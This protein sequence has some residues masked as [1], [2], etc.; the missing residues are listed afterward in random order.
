MIQQPTNLKKLTYLS[1]LIAFGIVLNLLEPNIFPVPGAKLGLANLVTLLSILW[2]GEGAGIVVAIFR[3]FL[4]SIFKGNLSLIP[5]GTSVFG[6]VFSAVI[7]ALLHRLFKKHFSIAGISIAGGIANNIAQFFFVILVT[8]NAAFWYYLPVLIILG[9][10]S[11]WGIGLL[12]L[13]VYNK[14]KPRVE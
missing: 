9:G 7:M 13:L 11:G 8:K 3:T 6:G 1:V 2:F 5:L 14:I 12:A 10:L 4:G